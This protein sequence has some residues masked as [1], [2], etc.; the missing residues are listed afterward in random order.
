MKNIIEEKP[1]TKLIARMK[2]TFMF[3]DK[4]DIKNKDVLD[5]GCGYGW[6]EV[7][8]LKMNVRHVTGIE[9]TEEDLKTIRRHITSKKF[10]AKVGS[11]IDIP[12]SANS[13]DTVVAWEVIEHIPRGT[14]KKFFSEVQRVLKKGGVFYLST[15]YSSFLSRYF[16]PAYWLIGHRHYSKEQLQSYF[17]KDK[18]KAE[19][20]KVY[21][22]KWNVLSLINMYTAKWIFRREKFLNNFFANESHKE[23]MNNKEG[24]F[25][26]F[27]KYRKTNS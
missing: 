11:A 20:M 23:Y 21:G 14:E 2:R 15:P 7:N 5:I 10:T 27:C 25:D 16:D 4:E 22:G 24:I 12:F 9:I 6:F 8:A 1:D 19:E 18:M 13:F 17:R 26:I 3:M